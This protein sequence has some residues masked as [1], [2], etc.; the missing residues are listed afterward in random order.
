MPGAEADT[1][2]AA[3]TTS[4]TVEERTPLSLTTQTGLLVVD[5]GD[6]GLS[7]DVNSGGWMA[8]HSPCPRSGRLHG[9][10]QMN[11]IQV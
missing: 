6:G 7:L 9:P 10:H 11:P 8:R 4:L 1:Q 3:N 5:S 2:T